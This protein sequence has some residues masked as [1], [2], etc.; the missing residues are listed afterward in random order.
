[1]AAL[2]GASVHVFQQDLNL[3]TVIKHVMALDDVSVVDVTHDLDLPTDLTAD[4]VLVVTVDYF[5]GVQLAR[6]AMDDFVDCAAG[7]ASDSIDSL[8]IGEIE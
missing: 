2:Q 1:M 5:E 6:W 8:Q 7:S 3:A 4:R